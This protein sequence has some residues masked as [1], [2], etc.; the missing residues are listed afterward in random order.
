MGEITDWRRDFEILQHIESDLTSLDEV[1]LKRLSGEKRA[2]AAWK[3]PHVE[4]RG[5][6]AGRKEEVRRAGQAAWH[7]PWAPGGRGPKPRPWTGP[8]VREVSKWRGAVE[9]RAEGAG[10]PGRRGDVMCRWLFDKLGYKQGKKAE[11]VVGRGKRSERK[12]FLLR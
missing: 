7:H 11:L 5:R 6:G 9:A 8:C 1:H 2:R 12:G 3:T 10:A 4:T